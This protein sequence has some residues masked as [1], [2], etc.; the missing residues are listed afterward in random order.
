VTA[1]V[2]LP[3]PPLGEP[4]ARMRMQVSMTVGTDLG[5]GNRYGPTALWKWC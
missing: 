1:V 3:T 4:T 5:N 2:V